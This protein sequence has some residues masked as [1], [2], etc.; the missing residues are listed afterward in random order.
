[1]KNRLKTNILISVIS[2]II[3]CNYS[4]YIAPERWKSNDTELKSNKAMPPS[5]VLI[6]VALGPIRGLI[7]D[8]LWWHVADLQERSEYFE[9]IKITDWITSMQPQNPYVWT[10]HA[11]NSAYNIAYEFPTPQTRWNWIQNGIKLLR[12]EGL[13]YNPGN[14]FIKS[15]LAFLIVDRVSGISDNQFR[16]YVNQW[17]K[18]MQK[19]LDKGNRQ[20]IDNMI[21]YIK[22]NPEFRQGKNPFAEK[23]IGI[24]EEMKLTPEKMLEV[25][26]QY[27]PFNWLL[28]QASAVYWGARKDEKSYSQGYLNY[29]S[30]LPVAMQQSFLRGAIVDNPETGLFITTN[31]FAI[32]PNIILM[33]EEKAK[34]SE[35]PHIENA[36]CLVFIRNALPILVSF[37][38]N[39]IAELLFAQYK[40]IRPEVAI[41]MHNFYTAQMLRLQDSGS[42]RYKQSIIEIPLFN[43]YRALLSDKPKRAANLADIAEQE[44][45][46]HQKKYGSTPF[47]LPPFD[48]IK[49]AAF[50]KAYLL[51]KPEF[52][53]KLLK[54]AGN[55]NYEK[56]YIPAVEKIRFNGTKLTESNENNCK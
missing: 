29:K 5:L 36:N 28:P 54:T 49:A 27:G 31:N 1:M 55:K 26:R 10:Y 43:A 53:L 51:N 41:N 35:K 21:S 2:L 19:Y 11:W 12:D 22:R 30:V 7:A 50:C 24:Q 17:S 15:E 25:D 6:T 44:W 40:K 14:D 9:I 33:Y 4:L 18:L 3:F 37:N 39:E 56:F 34:S 32:A 47:E 23:I 16:F 8:A 45:H 48:H 46:K 20:E 38:Q 52:R 42:A 13:K